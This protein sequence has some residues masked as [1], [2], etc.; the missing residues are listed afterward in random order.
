M[1]YADPKKR[2]ACAKAWRAKQDPEK[3]AAQGLKYSRAWRAKQDPEV[4]RAR[5]RALYADNPERVR[6]RK[7]LRY[8]SDVERNRGLDIV[9]SRRNWAERLIHNAGVNTKGRNRGFGGPTIT[10]EWILS[11]PLICPHLG[12]PLL[13]PSDDPSAGRH[14]PNAPSL[15]RIDNAKGYEP[16]NVRLTS[17]L[18]NRFRG[19]LEEHVALALLRTISANVSGRAA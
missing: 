7:R 8:A 1:P 13:V 9:K 19:N 6:A 17:W 2:A 14:S 10:K 5:A 11:Q 3:L 18:W 12:I 16:G 15:D 4:R